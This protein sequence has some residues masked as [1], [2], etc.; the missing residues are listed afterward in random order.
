M[1]EICFRQAWLSLRLG[2]F[3]AVCPCSANLN[4]I[5]SSLQMH[6]LIVV[7]ALVL[8]TERKEHVQRCLDVR[9]DVIVAKSAVDLCSLPTLRVCL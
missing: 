6:T 7:T 4:A 9:T 3:K 8:Q 5:A 2:S 1:P